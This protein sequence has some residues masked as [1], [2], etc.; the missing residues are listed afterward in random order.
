MTD[1]HAEA[2]DRT[3]IVRRRA[4]A[5]ARRRR[6]LM[7]LAV[8]L[9]VVGA[10]IG[11]GVA[12]IGSSPPRA[13]PPATT[14]TTLPKNHKT[15]LQVPAVS[16]SLASWTLP[17]AVRG[18]VVITSSHAGDLV[19]AGGLAAGDV[20]GQI[21]D[22]LDPSN[23]S[24]S[25]IGALSTPIYGA[26]SCVL[27]GAGF[28]FGGWSP[29]P[30]A[31][32]QQL[33]S[34]ASGGGVSNSGIASLLPEAR[35]GASAVVVGST[36]YVVGGESGAQADATVLSTT[37][38]V[39]FHTVATL[40]VPVIEPAVAAIGDQLV[41]FGGYAPSGANIGPPVRAIQT[42]D[43]ASGSVTVAGELP[44]PLAGATAI[45]LSGTVY[46]AGGETTGTAGA[47]D[48]DVASVYAWVPQAHRVVAVGSLSIAVANSGSDVIG[49]TAWLVGGETA[50]GVLTDR[51]QSLVRTGKS[52]TTTA[53]ASGVR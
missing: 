38:G 10:G 2:L 43:L 22:E 13:K 7:R 14:T 51:V 5:R 31:N 34:L 9:A 40:A 39:H 33:S 4:R 37:D 48:H 11:F 26:A 3:T 50:P 17:I 36:A 27:G 23:G 20:A 44:V 52:I 8:L 1:E 19:V 49:G 35:A 41:V 42:V 24:L 46:V 16:A 45:D 15:T 47:G 32:V 6:G 30:T 29:A 18:A 53:S 12:Q 21:V 25:E 28:I